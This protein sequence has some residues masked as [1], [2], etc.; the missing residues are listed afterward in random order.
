MS[1]FPKTFLGWGSL[2]C[3][4]AFAALFFLKV[5]THL[6]LVPSMIIFSVGIVGSILGIASLFLKERSLVMMI[7]TGL[8][9]IFIL[10]WL[11]GEIF[12]PH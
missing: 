2:A 12:S 6:I 3:A 11:M 4:V 10:F 1:T 8:V 7:V 5:Q 9:A